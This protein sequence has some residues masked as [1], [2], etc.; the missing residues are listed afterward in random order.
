MSS[1]SEYYYAPTDGGF[2]SAAAGESP[3][4]AV[5]ASTGGYGYL[6]VLMETPA[7]GDTAGTRQNVYQEAIDLLQWAFD[8]FAV[9]TVMEKGEIVEEVEVKYSFTTDHMPLSTAET[10]MTLMPNGVDLTSIQYR[11]DLPEAIAAPV[12]KGLEVGRLH[13][14]LADEEIGSVPLMT[15]DNVEASQI[16]TWLGWAEASVHTFWFKFVVLFIISFAILYTSLLVQLQRRKLRQGKY[17]QYR[18]RERG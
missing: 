11:Y 18:D 15:T 7:G 9:R 1:A 5:M 16:L 13:I 14:I 8:S 17:S 6:L 4:I 10:F 12:E 2:I 3:G